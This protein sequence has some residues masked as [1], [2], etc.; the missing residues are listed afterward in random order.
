MPLETFPVAT[1]EEGKTI[2]A[3]GAV[4]EKPRKQSSVTWR[5]SSEG[6]CRLVKSEFK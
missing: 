3:C 4:K 2:I 5:Q 1:E 6:M